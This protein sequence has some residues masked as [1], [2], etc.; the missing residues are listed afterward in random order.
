VY[1]KFDYKRFKPN[2]NYVPIWRRKPVKIIYAS[3][4]IPQD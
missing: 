3:T 4:F 1:K 2:K